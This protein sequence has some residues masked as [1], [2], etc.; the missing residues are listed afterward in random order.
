MIDNLCYLAILIA[1][2]LFILIGAK[3][4][5]AGAVDQGEV[6]KRMNALRG[7]FAI[8]VTIGHVFRDQMT[9]LYPLGKFMI[10]SVAFF[11]FLSGFGLVYSFHR[12]KDYLKPSFLIG[13]PLYLLT[14]TVLFYALY[15]VI[16]LICPKDL[17]YVSSNL[18]YSFWK[19]SNWYL[20]ELILFYLLFY[21]A[22]RFLPARFRIL[23]ITAV[24][25]AGIIGIYLY[26]GEDWIAWYASSLGFPL[27]LVFGEHYE[28][29]HDLLTGKLGITLTVLTALFGLSSLVLGVNMMSMVFMR[30][31]ICLSGIALLYLVVL[32]FRFGNK[33]MRLATKYSLEIYLTQF[34]FQAIARIYGWDLKFAYV[35]TT[36]CWLVTSIA[37]HPAVVGIKKLY[38]RM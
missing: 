1:F 15:I 12:K 16:D 28:Q 4:T 35:F 24:T 30:N 26:G 32:R 23:A 29:V 5:P 8:E 2:L 27:G 25:L 19:H 21:L 13:K 14:I 33:L 37:I 38:K 6:L 31:A 11:F 7:V 34:P 9:I 3:K 36:V 10:I 22:Y 20:F 18:L 17:G